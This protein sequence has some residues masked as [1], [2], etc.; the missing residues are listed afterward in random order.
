M[1]YKRPE[2]IKCKCGSIMFYRI[3]CL[4]YKCEACDNTIRK[5]EVK[6]KQKCGICDEIDILTHIT[7][8]GDNDIRIICF[9]CFSDREAMWFAQGEPLHFIDIRLLGWNEYYRRVNV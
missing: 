8:I 4:D 7:E 3:Q 6:I 9:D 1:E 2:T 5:E